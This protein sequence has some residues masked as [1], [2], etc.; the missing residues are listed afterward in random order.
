MAECECF[1]EPLSPIQFNCYY[2]KLLAFNANSLQIKRFL[3]T[4][5][6]TR[7]ELKKTAELYKFENK[8]MPGEYNGYKVIDLKTWDRPTKTRHVKSNHESSADISTQTNTNFINRSRPGN[9]LA[10]RNNVSNSSIGN[11]CTIAAGRHRIDSNCIIQKARKLQPLIENPNTKQR[12]ETVSRKILQWRPFQWRN[13]DYFNGGQYPVDISKQ[14]GLFRTDSQKLSVSL[15][16][17]SSPFSD[18]YEG[19]KLQ[20]PSKQFCFQKILPK[21][22]G[23]PKSIL[24][25]NNENNVSSSISETIDL[26]MEVENVSDEETSNPDFRQ[27]SLENIVKSRGIGE[28]FVGRKLYQIQVQKK[29]IAQSPVSQIFSS[30][31]ENCNT[32]SNL[33]RDQLP[34]LMNANHIGQDSS[35]RRLPINKFH[36]MTHFSSHPTQVD[37]N[38][39]SSLSKKDTDS[40]CKKDLPENSSRNFSVFSA[41]SKSD[42][43]PDVVNPKAP[44]TIDLVLS[45]A[46]EDMNLNGDTLM[47]NNLKESEPNEV[48]IEQCIEEVRKVIRDHLEYKAN[49]K[50]QVKKGSQ[51]VETEEECDEVNKSISDKQQKTECNYKEII[52]IKYLNSNAAN[53]LTNEGKFKSSSNDQSSNHI[54]GNNQSSSDK[55]DV[56][57]A[58][59]GSMS[60]HEVNC[61]SKPKSQTTCLICLASFKDEDN[62][63]SHMQENHVQEE[64]PYG[65]QVCGFRISEY[66]YI[67]DH[68]YKKHKGDKYIQCPFCLQVYTFITFTKLDQRVCVHFYNHIKKHLL[69]GVNRYCYKCCLSFVTDRMFET[70]TKKDHGTCK[71]MLVKYT[72]LGPN[73]DDPISDLFLIKRKQPENNEIGYK[74]DYQSLNLNHLP[75]EA[76]CIEC[77]GLLSSWV[78]LDLLNMEMHRAPVLS[79]ASSP[80][81]AHGD[82]PP[83][84]PAIFFLVFLFS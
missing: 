69:I 78:D 59:E 76:K 64:I 16:H 55:Y 61:N 57:K 42:S 39:E 18:N 47:L 60:N 84:H 6:A 80:L 74:F 56:N 30:H 73:L 25:K 71:T 63:L 68:F 54:D 41:T 7:I 33:D 48:N 83:S 8:C 45:D 5:N 3:S 23:S 12:N 66:R 26:T 38:K 37:V 36:S 34:L 50:S 2:S 24:I 43:L 58:G 21:P 11:I 9:P 31:P 77:R 75:L 10:D 53:S 79:S 20:Y 46:E 22:I 72:A 1:T 19:D 27:F 49:R 35:P 13:G 82:H 15:M 17:K 14:Q 62:L 44:E 32:A 51:G 29:L 81:S 40:N 65:C 28:S 67:I 4:R 70:H 52:G